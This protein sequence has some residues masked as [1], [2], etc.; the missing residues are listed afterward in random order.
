MPLARQSSI[1]A[2]RKTASQYHL[3]SL[4]Q[5]QRKRR[6]KSLFSLSLL[7]SKPITH[8]RVIKE[9]KFLYEASNKQFK[10]T[11]F[12]LQQRQT[13]QQPNSNSINFLLLIEWNWLLLEIE[14]LKKQKPISLFAEGGLPPAE[15]EKRLIVFVSR[16]APPAN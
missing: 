9:M 3:L 2:K 8:Y 10:K 4:I 5:Q 16:P 12:L 1:T 6:R 13:N 7:E 15:E 14:Q 11:T